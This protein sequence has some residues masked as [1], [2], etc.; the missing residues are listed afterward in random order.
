M[1]LRRIALALSLA[2]AGSVACA[3]TPGASSQALVGCFYFQ[4][5]DA[6]RDL[7]LPWG[8]ELTGD[9]LTGWPSLDQQ[10]ETYVAT[11]LRGPDETRDFPFGYWQSQPGD[12]VRIGYPGGGGLVLELTG[13]DD[14]LSGIARPVG[15]AGLG[16]RESHPVSLQRARCPE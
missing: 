7:G 8:V 5:D 12:S 13:S 10:P 4:Q 14:E 1:T 3:S 11:T 15:D 2:V 6:A 16:P 9:S